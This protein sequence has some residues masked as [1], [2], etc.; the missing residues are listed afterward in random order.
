MLF[1]YARV[2]TVEQNEAKQIAALQQLG[3]E[4]ENVYIDKQSGKDANR[5]KLK[6]LLDDVCRGDTVVTDSISRIARNTKDL[7]S[8]VEQLQG[9]G[10]EFERASCPATPQGEFMLTIFAAMAEL[11]R[12]SILQRQ[13]EGIAV[14]KAAGTQPRRF[15]CSIDITQ[16]PVNI[17][18][19]QLLA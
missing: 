7:L 17:P 2:S 19:W 10:I 1:G 8:I 5:P 3:V 11:E 12:K 15:L 9:K 14:A 4:T 6:E 18:Q 13:H 16:P